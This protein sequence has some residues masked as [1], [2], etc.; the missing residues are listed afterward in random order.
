MLQFLKDVIQEAVNLFDDSVEA[1]LWRTRLRMEDHPVDL[2]EERQKDGLV[3]LWPISED[4]KTFMREE[5]TWF[6]RHGRPSEPVFKRGG[7][8]VTWAVREEIHH[9]GLPLIASISYAYGTIIDT[10]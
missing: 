4:A 7:Y 3:I 2:A 6:D 10:P 5:I 8:L 9:N 1:F